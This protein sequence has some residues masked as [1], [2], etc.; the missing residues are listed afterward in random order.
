VEL[1]RYIPLGYPLYL[2]TLP[3]PLPLYHPSCY[4]PLFF[5][6]SLYSLATNSINI[7]NQARFLRLN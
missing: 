2:N 6:L 4:P 3:L 5:L 1:W 7:Y